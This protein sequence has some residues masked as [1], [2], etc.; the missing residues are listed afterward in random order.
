MSNKNHEEPCAKNLQIMHLKDNIV[1]YV[2]KSKGT[3]V[4]ML[5]VFMIIIMDLH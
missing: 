3:I 2:G 4:G 5:M 1:K